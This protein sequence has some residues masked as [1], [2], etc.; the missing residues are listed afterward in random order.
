MSTYYGV[1]TALGVTDFVT[2][3]C[4]RARKDAPFL[5]TVSLSILQPM[6]EE[7]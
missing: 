5:N 6:R 3:F 4:P 2:K 7:T 1:S